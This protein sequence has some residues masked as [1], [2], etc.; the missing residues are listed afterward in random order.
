M[1]KILNLYSGIGGNRKLWTKENLGF[2][3]EITAVEIDENIAKIYQDFFPNDEMIVGDAHNY[4]LHNFQDYDFIWSSPPCPTHS[5]M[6]YIY[7]KSGR[8]KIVY[9]DMKLYKEIIL[10]KS[11]FNN[12][13]CIENVNSYYEPLIKPQIIDRH[14]YWS[15]FHIAKAKYHKQIIG[16]HSKTRDLLRIQKELNIKIE[17]YYNYKGEKGLLYRN[18]VEPKIGLHILNCAYNSNTLFK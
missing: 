5:K 13:F 18:C 11:F 6:K 1:I 7:Q 16:M 9:P 15:N 14:Y 8:Q 3:M 4:L 17:N 10:L 12:K 2:D